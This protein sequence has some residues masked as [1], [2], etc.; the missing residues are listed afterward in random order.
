MPAKYGKRRKP[1]PPGAKVPKS[2]SRRPTPWTTLTIRSEH[3]AMLRELAEFYET[4]IGQV[5]M[6]LI[7]RDFKKRLWEQQHAERPRHVPRA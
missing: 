4:T 6:D 3:Y 2:P 1:S 5:A 7:E